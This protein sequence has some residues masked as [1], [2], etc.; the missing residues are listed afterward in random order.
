MLENIMDVINGNKYLF[1][2]IFTILDHSG[3][4]VP[5]I[6]VGMFFHVGKISFIPA[7]LIMNASL[8]VMDVCLIYLGIY[9]KKR[10]TNKRIYPSVFLNIEKRIIRFGDN[11]VK[12]ES[13][14]SFLFG[15]FVPYVGK[16][17]PIY[18]GYK[19]D[20]QKRDIFLLFA[21]N[22]IYIVTFIA[23]GMVFGNILIS[24]SAIGAI[25]CFVGFVGIYSITFKLKNRKV[26]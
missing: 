16:F 6:T 14:V 21:G 25:V 17:F 20:I 2:F 15:K 26:K 4:P 13:I 1:L 19:S 7:F 10:H 12:K 3:I 22:N 23:I 9:L 18:I 11:I 5:I 8:L 24:Y